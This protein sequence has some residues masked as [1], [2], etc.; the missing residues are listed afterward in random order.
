MK[1]SELE[2]WKTEGKNRNAMWMILAYDKEDHEY[3]PVYVYSDAE[4]SVTQ[5]QLSISEG[6]QKVISV[7][8]L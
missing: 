3:Y 1:T 4:L 6:K 8:R 2:G 5:R 7:H